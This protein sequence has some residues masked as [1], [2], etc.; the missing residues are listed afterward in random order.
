MEIKVP[1]FEKKEIEI[2]EI[3][4]DENNRIQERTKKV[5]LPTRKIKKNIE[6]HEEET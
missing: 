2:R 4:V 5:W 6:R 1:L 3:Y